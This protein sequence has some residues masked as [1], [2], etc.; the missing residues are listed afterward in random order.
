MNK[1]SLI[2]NEAHPSL[3]FSLKKAVFHKNGFMKL[4]FRY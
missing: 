1:G 3:L 2:G 4:L